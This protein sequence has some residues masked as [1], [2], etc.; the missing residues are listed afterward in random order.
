MQAMQR[1]CPLP[2]SSPGKS[3]PIRARVLFS[4]P[5]AGYA[6]RY[7]GLVEEAYLTVKANLPVY[8]I[9]AFGGCTRAIIDAIEGRRPESL[10]LAGQIRLDEK[11]AGRKRQDHRDGHPTPSAPQTSSPRCPAWHRARR[12]P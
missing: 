1:G 12:L 6:D 5:L 2:A 8:L 3:D 4:G 11:L 10:T 9:G 7:P